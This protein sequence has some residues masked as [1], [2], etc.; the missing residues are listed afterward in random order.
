MSII[1]VHTGT[2]PFVFS[3]AVL[4]GTIDELGGGKFANGAVTGAFSIMFNDM[5]HP[6]NGDA[7]TP[8]FEIIEK[9]GSYYMARPDGT[10]SLCG[11]KPLEPICP[12]F[13][14]ILPVRGFVDGAVGE[15]F[16]LFKTLSQNINSFVQYETGG[17]KQWVRYG[18]SYSRTGNF[19]TLKSLKWGAGKRHVN[20]IHNKH[21]RSLNKN[22]RQY[23]LP[24][25]SWRMNDPGHFHIEKR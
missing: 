2:D 7:V 22:I 16:S 3:N 4:C 20:K 13:D 10:L 1:L 18:P 15:T 9:G 14:I 17:I 24:G 25:N 8:Q 6:Q 12:E 5:M 23:K 11:E 21:L 19:K